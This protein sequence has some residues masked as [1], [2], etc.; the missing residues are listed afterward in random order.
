MA[1]TNQVTRNNHWDLWQSI[2]SAGG[3]NRYA[4][5]VAIPARIGDASKIKHV[6]VII[7]ENRTY[8]QILAM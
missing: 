5:P 4:P 8:D 7:R 6:F 2:S 3:G 1:P